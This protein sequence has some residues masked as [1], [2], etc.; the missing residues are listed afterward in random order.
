MSDVLPEGWVKLT[1]GD[2]L[3]HRKMM[4]RPGEDLLSVTAKSG[5]IRQSESGR[6]DISSGDKSSYNKVFPGDIVYNTMRMWQGVSGVAGC[7]GIVSPA[8][9]VCVPNNL[10]HADFLAYL[11]KH[12]RYVNMFRRMSQGLVSDT[13]NLKFSQFAQLA[14]LLPSLLEQRKITEVLAVVDESIDGH[15]AMIG[16]LEDVRSGVVDS[17]FSE[18]NYWP[19]GELKSYLAALPKNG[20]SPSE[21]D[22]WTGVRVLGLGCL[23][24]VGFV[25]RQLKNV[26]ANFV[27][28]S[29]SLLEVGDLLISRANTRELV[30]LVGRYE[31]VG[32]PCLYPDLMMRLKPNEKIDQG[33]LEASLRHSYVRRQIMA[34]AVGTSESMVKISSEI[35]RSLRISV[36][37]LERQRRI[38]STIKPHAERIAVEQARLEKLRKLKAGLMDDLLTGRV[39]VNQ[40]KDLSV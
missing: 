15:Q 7:S 29:S 40:L 19:S 28:V 35:V 13:W 26:P 14:V 17:I 30:G 39:R 21:V 33:F 23:T 8:Y 22:D 1:F 6:R 20:F 9:T 4:G 2:I 27:S 32:G 16:K 25:P 10:V 31:D 36:P 38:L 11:L 5:V 37:S 24:H 34:R 12:P 18:H 3:S